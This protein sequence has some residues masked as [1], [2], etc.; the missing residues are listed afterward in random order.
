VTRARTLPAVALD[1]DFYTTTAQVIPTLLLTLV[2][3][4]AFLEERKK[5]HGPLLGS[6]VVL[7][8]LCTMVI[9][10]IAALMAL[11]GIRHFWLD[12]AV[13]CAV[14][15]GAIAV[16]SPLALRTVDTAVGD[17][18]TDVPAS[19]VAFLLRACQVGTITLLGFFV[20]FI[21]LLAV[22]VYVATTLV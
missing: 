4:R 16:V 3:E 12:Y 10:E 20:A 21:P 13:V 15:F 5:G 7:A 6:L 18:A 17:L 11:S 19:R 1:T 22:F 8:I 2:V 9:G 14:A